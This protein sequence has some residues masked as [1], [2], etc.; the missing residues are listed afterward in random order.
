MVF[1][2]NNVA[3]YLVG[4]ALS[5]ALG[6]D[7]GWFIEQEILAPLG[8]DRFEYGRCPEGYFY[9]ASQMILS[10][11][12]LS[13]LGLLLLGGGMY[14]G[15]R[16]LSAKYVQ[17]ATAVQQMNR[18]GGYGYYLWK[19]RDGFSINGKWGQKCWV[20]PREG[21]MVTML[22]HLEK[23]SHSIRECMEHYILDS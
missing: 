9:G 12:S 18:E 7:L 15:K 16:I 1:H 23:D 14:E 5:E 19:Y 2:Y 17:R 11:N 20:L 4:V 3:P 13:R 22:A 6:Q 10:V 8:I 21:I